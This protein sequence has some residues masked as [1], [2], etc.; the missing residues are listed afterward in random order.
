LRYVTAAED[1]V[2]GDLTQTTL[3]LP[4]VRSAI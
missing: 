2:G 4:A 1:E 3:H